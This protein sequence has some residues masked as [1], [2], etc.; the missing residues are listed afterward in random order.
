MKNFT[1]TQI[2][3]IKQ[4]EY[5]TPIKF[6][7]NRKQYNGI[8]V[9]M[10]KKVVETK[11]NRMYARHS[12]TMPSLFQTVRELVRQS[13]ESKGTPYFKTLIEGNTGIYYASP[14]YGHRDYNKTR[15]CD[16]NDTTLKIMSLFN[17]LIQK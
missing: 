1:Q 8:P 9:E 16:K 17:S 14:S 13:R 15:I 5:Y 10:V 7:G 4:L 12:G 11:Q 2:D 6:H 3:A